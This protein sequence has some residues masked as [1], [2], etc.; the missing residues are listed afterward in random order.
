MDGKMWGGYHSLP[1]DNDD[2]MRK[3][4]N[5][6]GCCGRK[7]MDVMDGVLVVS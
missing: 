2:V 3:G 4:P 5:I 6:A 7:L 1:P